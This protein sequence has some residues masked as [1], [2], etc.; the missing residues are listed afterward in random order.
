MADDDFESFDNLDDLDWSDVEEEL[1]ANK[2]AI[3]AEAAKQP[4]NEEPDAAPDRG[5]AVAP[6]PVL[7]GALDI[8][9][10]LD[11]LLQISVEVGRTRMMIEDLL[12]LNEES[13][14]ELNTTIGQPLD[15]RINDKLVARGEVVVI[16]DKFA[17]RI[18]DIVS[19][20]DRFA[21]L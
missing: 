21:A 1:K 3:L 11:V 12:G 20:D 2:Q 5:V 8:D 10:L 18:T 9:F 17:I 6:K 4:G 16:N 14:I 19:P 15:I 7:D 13:I